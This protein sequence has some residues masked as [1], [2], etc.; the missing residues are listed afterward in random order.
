[1]VT[2]LHAE[3]HGSREG[4]VYGS[5]EHEDYARMRHVR[6]RLRPDDVD[7]ATEAWRNRYEVLVKGDVE[8]RGN[9]VRMRDV[10]AFVVVP[11]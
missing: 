8:P 5:F 6:V 4:T 11:G 3:D 1:M 9:G 7:R 10:T 2:R